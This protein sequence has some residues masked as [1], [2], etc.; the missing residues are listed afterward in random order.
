MTACTTILG[1]L[2]M[3]IGKTNVAGMQYYPLA[4]AVIGG[5]AMGTIL[6]L[7]ALPT[8]YVIGERQKHWAKRVWA[9]AKQPRRAASD[10][11]S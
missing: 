11:P 2:P 4:R 5:L 7:I 1:L 9:R 8:F 10:T 6:T 3:A